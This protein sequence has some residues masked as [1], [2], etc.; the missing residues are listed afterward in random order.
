LGSYAPLFILLGL[1]QVENKD[2]GVLTVSQF[3]V[4]YLTVVFLLIAIV[5]AVALF[6]VIGI[7]K[8]VAPQRLQ[9]KIVD[10]NN[11]ET[12]AYLITYLIP[13]VGFQ[14]TSWYSISA[15]IIV[16]MLI[17]FLYVQS[18]MIYLNPLLGIMGYRVN[19]IEINGK[20]KLLLTKTQLSDET[21]VRLIAINEGVYLDASK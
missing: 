10:K 15:N 14:F 18:N 9:I 12:L 4:S 17:G 7:A 13:F 11:Q 6:V 1:T 5:G 2:F 21:S 16:F 19:K 3:A 20:Q 8:Q